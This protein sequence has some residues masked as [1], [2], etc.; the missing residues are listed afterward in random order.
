MIKYDFKVNPWQVIEQNFPRERDIA[1]RLSFLLR[2]AILAP[3]NHNTQPWKF[4]INEDE[5]RVYA[6]F[7]RWLKVAD[8]RPTRVTHQRRMRA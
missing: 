2:Y 5:V 7:D 6:N 8:A 3:S 4:A 1:Q